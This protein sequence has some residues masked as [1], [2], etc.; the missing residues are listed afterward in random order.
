MARGVSL[1][2][3]NTYLLYIYIYLKPEYMAPY[4]TNKWVV[5]LQHVAGDTWTLGSVP[6]VTKFIIKHPPV[7]VVSH[8]FLPPYLLPLPLLF[9]PSEPP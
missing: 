3:I 9:T 7:L 5:G 8:T 4:N 1:S 6:N 2:L